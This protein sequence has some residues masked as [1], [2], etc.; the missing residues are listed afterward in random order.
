VTKGREGARVRKVVFEE[1]G[2][3]GELGK[4]FEGDA[5]VAS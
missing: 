1:E 2:V 4:N 5:L 3:V